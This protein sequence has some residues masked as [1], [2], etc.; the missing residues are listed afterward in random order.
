MTEIAFLQSKIKEL[1]ASIRAAEIAANNTVIAAKTWSNPI[2]TGRQR[3]L[4]PRTELE[5]L[6]LAY[7]AAEAERIRVESFGLGFDGMARTSRMVSRPTFA[8]LERISRINRNS[9][10]DSGGGPG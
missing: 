8:D 10:L 7:P 2:L 9:S 5:P 1:E 6:I 3:I 4:R